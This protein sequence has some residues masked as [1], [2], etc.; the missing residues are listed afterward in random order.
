MRSGRSLGLLCLLGLLVLLAGC[1]APPAPSAAPSLSAS[2]TTQRTDEGTNAMS[3]A[4][5]NLGAVAVTVTRARLAWTGMEGE[6]VSLDRSIAADDATA[7]KAPYREGVCEPL[8]ATPMLQVEVEKSVLSVPV[9]VH[10]DA[11]LDSIHDRQCALAALAENA[12][13]S[14]TQLA[15]VDG[16]VEATLL[17]TRVSGSTAPV[18]VVDLGGSVL[19][20]LAFASPSG[21][22]LTGSSLQVP[23]T[24]SPT[25]RCDP[26]AQSQSSQTFLLSAYLRVGE[27]DVRAILPLDA[28]TKATLQE[29][30]NR[31]CTG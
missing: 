31:Y 13:V 15:V 23:I 9:R 30:I 19:L 10:P 7:F 27:T 14:L 11:V 5:R 18:E 1:S 6:W 24:I 17:V 21:R 20:R 26:H 4:I 25:P 2:A 29:L 16:A 12:S 3:V 28:E 8:G 22:A